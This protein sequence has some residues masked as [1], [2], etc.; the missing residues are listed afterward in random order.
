VDKLI[1][2]SVIRVEGARTVEWTLSSSAEWF[3]AA[4]DIFGLTLDDLDGDDRARLWRDAQAGH[5]AY[6]AS[7]KDRDVA[8]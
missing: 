6:L 5:A 2:R 7:Q 3:A 8:G 4:A 1:N